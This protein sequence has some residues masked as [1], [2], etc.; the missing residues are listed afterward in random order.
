MSAAE[1]LDEDEEPIG[2]QDGPQTLFAECTADIAI[3]GGAAGAGKSFALLYEAAKW[4]VVDGVRAFRGVLFRRTNPE[5]VGSG[6]LWDE[7]Q[8]LYRALAGRPRGAPALDWTFEAD[9]TRIVDRHRIELRHLVHEKTV[10]EHQGR[11][12]AFVGF[13][14]VTHF[15]SRQFWYMYGRLRSKCGVRPYMRATCNPDPDSFVAE[16]I[17]WWIGSDGYPLPERS[18]VVRWLVRGEND[19]IEWFETEADARAEHPDVDPVSFTF[20]S[21]RLEDNPALL[22]KDPSY[23]S[24]LMSQGRVDRMRL[25]GGEGGKRGGNWA[26][27]ESAGLFFKRDEFKLSHEPPSRIVRQI[28]FWDKAASI[29]TPKHPDP[30]WTRGVRVALCAD[31]ELWIDDMVSARIRA[32]EGLKL[33]QRTAQSDGVLVEVGFWQDTAGAGKT[34]AD[35]TSDALAGFALQVVTSFSADT[36]GVHATSGSSRA[37]RA[38]AKTWA[39]MVERGR[40]YVRRAEWTHDL[41][42]ECDGFPDAKHDDIVDAISGAA[43]VLIPAGG[44][45]FWGLLKDAADA[46]EG[47]AR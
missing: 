39:P 10:F 5:L 35:V 12:Y 42:G 30:D 43:Q 32:V 2:P 47:M 1:R 37:K 24:K 41:L 6:G 15:T 9:S 38:F 26:I 36:T 25:F 22:K 21:G 44:A 16:L 17:A 3:Y 23:R 31:G 11:Q 46:M 20:I 34:D 40:V 29:P 19:A 27:R 14:E 18:G 13:D 33:M 8:E 7:S 45:G 4:C 28:R